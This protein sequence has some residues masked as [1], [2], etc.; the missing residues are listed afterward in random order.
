MPL[1]NNPVTADTVNARY[2]SAD[3]LSKPQLT[4]FTKNQLLLYYYML[5]IAVSGIVT[6]GRYCTW[7]LLGDLQ[8]R[9]SFHS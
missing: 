4:S 5:Y 9:E 2:R 3:M 7:F 1:G 6:S 8:W